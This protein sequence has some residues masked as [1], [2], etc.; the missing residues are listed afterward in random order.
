[1][2]KFEVL[3]EKENPVLKRKE[4]VISLDYQQGSTPSKMDLQKALSE[5]MNANIEGIEISKIISETGLP[6][7]KAWVKIWQEKKIPLYK[8]KEKPK[9]EAPKPEE[10]KQG[11][12]GAKPAEQPK[13]EKPKE[14]QKGEQ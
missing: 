5:Q 10:P 2:M 14:E 4:L 8:K 11:P 9:E 6:M 3:E 12:Q 13:E 1:M 7:G